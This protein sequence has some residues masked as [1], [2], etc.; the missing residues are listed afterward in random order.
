M[1]EL[2]GQLELAHASAAAAGSDAG[3]SASLGNSPPAFTAGG[4]NS[5]VD[6]RSDR[7]SQTSTADVQKEFGR[8]V[9]KDANRSRYVSSGFWS[10]VD[11][12]GLELQSHV[13]LVPTPLFGTY[14]AHDQH[15]G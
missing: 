13:F 5:N 15:Q 3:G 14:L 7:A 2:S 12:S 1:R 10:R 4:Y 8:L 6:G 11:V 9:L